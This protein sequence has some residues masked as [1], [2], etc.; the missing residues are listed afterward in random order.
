MK[1]NK[2]FIFT[3]YFLFHSS[4]LF[5]DEIYLN[6]SSINKTNKNG[7][8]EY[9]DQ[10]EFII[11][12]DN[13]KLFWVKSFEL[14]KLENGSIKQTR[15]PI[16]FTYFQ[17]A[18]GL[19]VLFEREFEDY[20]QFVNVHIDGKIFSFKEF[21]NYDALKGKNLETLYSFSIYKNLKKISKVIFDTK[22]GKPFPQINYECK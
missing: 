1:K 12:L 7:I 11:D 14:K 4:Y 6:C 21:M 15:D 9:I 5:S 3:I 8:I 19:P 16:F 18:K 13:K 2:I 20:L 10:D 22:T 17:D